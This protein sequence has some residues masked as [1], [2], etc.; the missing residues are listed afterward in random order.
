M[1]KSR[2]H[3]GSTSER[4][5]DLQEAGRPG[6]QSMRIRLT[7]SIGTPAPRQ[8]PPRYNHQAIARLFMPS[9]PLRGSG[10]TQASTCAHTHRWRRN[11]SNLR[12]QVRLR[13]LT[14]MPAVACALGCGAVSAWASAPRA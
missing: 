8:Q 11:G 7:S 4:S 13:V 12:L 3:F 1:G 2:P 14:G 9:L 6:A 5:I 10:P